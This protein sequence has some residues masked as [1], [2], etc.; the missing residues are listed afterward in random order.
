MP[1][2]EL[3]TTNDH[4]ALLRRAQA[5][6]DR[7]AWMPMPASVQT[8]G[9]LAYGELW[10]NSHAGDP[11]IP[12]AKERL[13]RLR[14]QLWHERYDERVEGSPEHAERQVWEQARAEYEQAIAEYLDAVGGRV[15]VRE[16]VAL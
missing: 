15:Q 1:I 12:A 13:G 7:W 9:N 16:E 2:I 6:W 11:R 8:E 14:A 3:G 5:A 10:C 4:R